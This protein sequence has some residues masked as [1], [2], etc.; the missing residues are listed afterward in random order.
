[1][2]R[3][4]KHEPQELRIDDAE[5]SKS[6]VLQVIHDPLNSSASQELRSASAVGTT[7]LGSQSE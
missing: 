1:M 6:S 4:A 5:E 2:E 7:G 3:L